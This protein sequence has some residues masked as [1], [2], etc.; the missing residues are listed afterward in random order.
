MMGTV[1]MQ[2]TLYVK[3]AEYIHGIKKLCIRVDSGIFLID[4]KADE[5][6][7]LLI[8]YQEIKPDVEISYLNIYEV[9]N[10]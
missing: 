5:V 1:C 6:D 9:K 8:L 3:G 2:C 7:H 10:D 4:G